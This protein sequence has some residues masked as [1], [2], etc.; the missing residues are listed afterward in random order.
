MAVSITNSTIA[1]LNTH[2]ILTPNAATS[3]EIGGSEVFTFTPKASGGKI[4]LIFSE[5]STAA[6]AKASYSI[7]AGDMWASKAIT[8]SIGS[9]TAAGKLEVLEI[10]TA[11]VMQD[12]GT[13]LITVSPGDTTAA[14]LLGTHHMSMYA[15]ELLQGV[16]GESPLSCYLGGSRR[17]YE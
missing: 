8:G 13:I 5:A 7:A 6:T 11:L 4:A 2:Q 17:I 3:T 15:I 9:T 14:M 12:D 10:D 16:G 1:A